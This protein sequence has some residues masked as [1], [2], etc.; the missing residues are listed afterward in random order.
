MNKIWMFVVVVVMAAA[1]CDQ[2]EAAISSME[3][4]KADAKVAEAKLIEAKLADAKTAS[5]EPNVDG[6]AGTQTAAKL[7]AHKVLDDAIAAAKTEDK[8][9]LVHFTADW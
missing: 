2:K 1:G 5:T 7:D 6:A 9:L 3:K 8:A 4:A